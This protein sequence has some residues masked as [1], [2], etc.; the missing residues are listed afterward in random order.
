MQISCHPLFFTHVFSIMETISTFGGCK[1]IFQFHFLYMDQL[2]LLY[3]FSF[4]PSFS[5]VLFIFFIFLFFSFALQK[6][7]LYEHKDLKKINRVRI[8]NYYFFFLVLKLSHLAFG[9]PFKTVPVSFHFFPQPHQFFLPISFRA[10]LWL[11]VQ[12]VLG[13]HLEVLLPQL[14]LNIVIL[15]LK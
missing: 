11:L 5:L 15:F 14:W 6:Y 1:V 10:F 9:S 4:F 12:G 7:S 3:K 13:S 2:A 8:Y